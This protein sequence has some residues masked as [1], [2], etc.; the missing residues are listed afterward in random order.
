MRDR[1]PLESMKNIGKFENKK[2]SSFGGNSA[3][4][5]EVQSQHLTKV[6]SDF[7]VKW[8][9]VKK[10]FWWVPELP[11][12]QNKWK[13]TPS[14]SYSEWIEKM[15]KW[16]LEPNKTLSFWENKWVIAKI[17]WKARIILRQRKLKDKMFQ[18]WLDFEDI[19]NLDKEIFH[20]ILVYESWTKAKSRVI[21]TNISKGKDKIAVAVWLDRKWSIAEIN[22]VTSIHPKDINRYLN[23]KNSWKIN[24]VEFE[25]TKK[26][27]EWL[28]SASLKEMQPTTWKWLNFIHNDKSTTSSWIWPN[29]IPKLP[30]VNKK[31]DKLPKRDFLDRIKKTDDNVLTSQTE[32]KK[33]VEKYF[34]PD[35]VWVKLVDKI[36]TKE[37]YEAFWKYKDRLISFAKDPSKNTPDHEVFHAYF[38]LALSPKQKSSLLVDIKRRKWLK[39]DLEAEEFLANKFADYAIWRRDLTWVS[40]YVRKTIENLWYRFKK[41]FWNEDKVETL[42]KDLENVWN[43]KKKFELKFGDKKAGDKYFI[44]NTWKTTEEVKALKIPKTEWKDWKNKTW[45]E[46]SKI[47]DEEKYVKNSKN[48]KKYWWE[49]VEWIDFEKM[50]QKYKTLYDNY[51]N[52]VNKIEKAKDGEVSIFWNTQILNQVKKLWINFREAK[53]WNWFWRTID[54]RYIPKE[55]A[56]KIQKIL[57]K[58]LDEI[59]DKYVGKIKKQWWKSSEELTFEKYRKQYTEKPEETI[60]EAL[61][62]LNK[63][64]KKIRDKRELQKDKLF[65]YEEWVWARYS[66]WQK[67]Q[68]HEKLED[69]YL[70][71]SNIYK[72]KDKYLRK[73]IEK[74]WIEPKWYHEFSNGDKM[75]YYEFWGR[76]FHIKE[77]KSEKYLWDIDEQISS[78]KVWK[79]ISLGNIYKILDLLFDDSI[80]VGKVSK[81][82]WVPRLPKLS[83]LSNYSKKAEAEP[84]YKLKPIKLPPKLPKKG[85]WNLSNIWKNTWE[86]EKI[87]NNIWEKVLYD[88]KLTISN[89]GKKIKMSSDF[90]KIPDEAMIELN[91]Y[92][93]N[94]NNSHLLLENLSPNVNKLF[95]ASWIDVKRWKWHAISSDWIKHIYNNHWVKANLK[96]NEIPV[97]EE[98]IKLI[99]KIIKEADNVSI[100]SKKSNKWNIVI[101]YEKN[102]W[103]KYYYLEYLNTK[104]DVLET[105]TMYINKI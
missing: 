42:F 33:V 82:K 64:A 69:M 80:K 67:E 12:L 68:A 77:N 23:E 53:K 43:W 57:K 38:D 78:E 4:L 30:K 100:S 17:F 15:M 46:K 83:E 1:N 27:Q 52:F 66:E 97:T 20:P 29:Y 99:P 47:W 22:E 84:M 76:W 60:A 73:V 63:E 62:N 45:D 79:K 81:P 93:W 44:D 48:I 89:N 58:E 71:M 40:G 65:S 13:I 96:S 94:A 98:D 103:N 18:H 101:T 51:L 39:T 54:D 5:K 104:S 72:N 28:G 7:K 75:D 26:I 85:N 49:Y 19:K 37:W 14:V 9:K 56:K 92:I 32:A 34:K 25:N 102:I 10:D 50:P 95:K 88:W 6:S 61:Y 21:V 87:L 59:S 2:D 74:F 86:N 16:T 36:T 3:P 24:K 8:E 35:E 105:Q 90:D 31:I 41:F 11:K 70:D 91:K 55:E